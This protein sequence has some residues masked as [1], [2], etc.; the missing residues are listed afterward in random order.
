MDNDVFIFVLICVEVTT[1]REVSERARLERNL[2][3]MANL[4][5]FKSI[6]AGPIQTRSVCLV[7]E[8]VG[9]VCLYRCGLYRFK[10]P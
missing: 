1:R 10:C 3:G 5:A 4:R 2:E 8:C 9:R 6:Q 7:E